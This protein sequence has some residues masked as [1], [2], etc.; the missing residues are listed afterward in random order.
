MRLLSIEALKFNAT[1]N[2]KNL[3]ALK[4]IRHLLSYKSFTPVQESI[5]IGLIPILLSFAAQ[6]DVE[7]QV[8]VQCIGSWKRYGV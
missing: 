1:D 7:M 2:T 5:D 8:S 6:E 4:S 3:E